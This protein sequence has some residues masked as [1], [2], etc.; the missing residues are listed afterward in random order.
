MDEGKKIAPEDIKY[1]AKEIEKVDN[2]VFFEKPADLKR[3]EKEEARRARNEAKRVLKES[4]N[5][6]NGGGRVKQELDDY[7]PMS[8]E[9]RAGIRKSFIA[10]LI[11]I[12]IL[13]VFVGI[14]AGAMYLCNK[15]WGGEKPWTLSDEERDVVVYSLQDYYRGKSDDEIDEDAKQIDEYL[16]G[17]YNRYEDEKIRTE[18]LYRR[19][20]LLYKIESFTE[21]ELKDA[22]EV[23]KLDKSVR[24]ANLLGRIYERLGDNENAERYN[25]IRDERLRG[26]SSEEQYGEG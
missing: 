10:G 9:K 3:K 22:Q 19:I 20:E 18:C 5:V 17:I 16:N 15:I 26:L 7:V 12:G 24:S 13:A 2:S 4:K 25:Q 6:K 1:R 21:R 23:E 14:S 8:T 11:S